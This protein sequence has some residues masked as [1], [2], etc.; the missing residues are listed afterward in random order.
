MIAALDRKRG[1]L[2]QHV[3][4]LGDP[5]LSG[6]HVAGKDQGLGTGSAFRQAARN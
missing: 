2:S 4:G 5:P 6:K 3:A 1:I